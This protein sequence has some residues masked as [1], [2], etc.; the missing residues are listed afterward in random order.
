M[1]KGG[2]G[3]GKVGGGGQKGGARSRRDQPLIETGSAVLSGT[4]ERAVQDA[5]LDTVKD[6]GFDMVPIAHIADRS[7]VSDAKLQEYIREQSRQGG[8][9]LSRGDW[10]LQSQRERDLALFNV[11]G[12][13]KLVPNRAKGE[14][15]DTIAANQTLG[16]SVEINTTYINAT[17]TPKGQKITANM[18]ANASAASMPTSFSWGGKVIRTEK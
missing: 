15:S 3:T 6:R 11:K 17:L 8:A 9:K 4:E 13:D 7:G 10:S 14:R 12:E 2:G 18:P 5:Y 16:R 1:A